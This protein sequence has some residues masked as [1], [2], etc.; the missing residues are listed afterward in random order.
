MRL[1]YD[2]E[3]DG[4][5][6]QLSK[7]HI[8][9]VK[10]VDNGD[11]VTYKYDEIDAALEHLD[12]ATLLVGHNIILFDN[13][14]LEKVT[15]WKPKCELMDTLVMSRMLWSNISD[16]DWSTKP[17]DMPVKLYG[18]HS[19]KAWGFRLG[20]NKA[21]YKGSWDYW[22]EE[23]HLY[24]ARDAAVTTKLFHKIHNETT[25]KEA[26]ELSH[27]LANVCRDIENAGWYFD[28]KKAGS[29]VS[30]LTQK[31][32]EIRF[33][34]DKVYDDWY[35]PIQE[36]IPKVSVRN[37]VKGIPY[38]KIKHNSFNPSSRQMIANRLTT[39][40]GWK[41]KEFTPS[42]QPKVDESVLSKLP[43]DEAQKLAEYFLLDKRLG[44]IS[45]GSQAWLKLE[46]NGKL[47]HQILVNNCVTQRVSHRNPNLAQVPSTR[48]PYGKECRSLFGVKPG[49]KLVGA[50]YQG[51]ELR[52]L[53]HYL[54]KLDNGA[55]AKEVIEGD[56]HSKNAHA[57]GINRD[58]A[59]TFIYALIYSAGA[60]RLGE[61]VGGNAREGSILRERFFKEYP[62]FKTLRN[63]V[64]KAAKRGFLK[65]LDGRLLRVRSEHSALNL[66]LQ[67]AGAI[68]CAKWLVL[69]DKD[70]KKAGY[71]NGWDNDYNVLTWCH[72]ELQVSVTEGL[73]NDTGDRLCRMAEEAG[74]RLNFRCKV[75]AEYTVGENWAATH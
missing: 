66:L 26:T 48:S 21:E 8:I 34:L 9:A 4:L 23:M 73:E 19:L 70:M 29:L 16:I 15:G 14:A 57:L 64:L 50:D 24:A 31:R 61:I 37:R 3:T 67:S 36:V 28:L 38:T 39:I 71:R 44:M 60:Q 33:A 49:W 7:I 20:E 52:C 51:L 10:D 45:E 17:K 40:N 62:A 6:H 43:F 55:F 32:E 27:D 54:A 65:G 75:T 12:K 56:I 46:Q 53:G 58:L 63:Q 47:H 35:S 11:A 13:P 1:C 22:N 30:D 41:P 2:I 69:F 59:K 42:G 18:S 68:L 25:S 5:L 74:R 72:D